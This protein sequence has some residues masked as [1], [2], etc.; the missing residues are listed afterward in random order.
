MR[1]WKSLVLVQCLLA[2]GVSGY[3]LWPY[4]ERYGE[5]RKPVDWRR[6]GDV[7]PIHGEA[8]HEDMVPFFYGYPMWCYDDRLKE[9]RLA[10]EMEL[11]NAVSWAWA[12][13]CGPARGDPGYNQGQG[14]LLPDMP[15]GRRC[16]GSRPRI[17]HSQVAWLPKTVERHG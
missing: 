11:P 9:E 16:L 5:S 6:T 14:Q 7:C 4:L 15:A 8:L 1:A 3:M 10:R 12:G 2:Q 17:H 13:S